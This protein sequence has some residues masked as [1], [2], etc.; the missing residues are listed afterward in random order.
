MK[1]TDVKV[2]VDKENAGDW[3][4]SP[5]FPELWVKVRSIHNADF[6]RAMQEETRKTR[7]KY[8]KQP[9][10][11]DVEEKVMGRAIVD[12]ILLDIQGLED[13]NDDPIEYDREFGLK[14]MTDPAYRNL[15]DLVVWAANIVGE[16]MSDEI[17]ED[18]KN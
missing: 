9:V 15:S 10:P 4:Q 6:R 1:I 17:E 18:V 13:E 8:G 2:D 14:I 11:V 3:V 7:R 12:H 16:Q 5:Q